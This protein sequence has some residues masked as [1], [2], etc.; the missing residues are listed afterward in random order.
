VQTLQDYLAQRAERAEEFA[1]AS[2]DE[3]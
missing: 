1:G 3:G 2:E